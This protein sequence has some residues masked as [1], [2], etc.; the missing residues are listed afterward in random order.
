VWVQDKLGHP[1]QKS[2]SYN[3][4]LERVR[5]GKVIGRDQG[6]LHADQQWRQ[7]DALLHSADTDASSYLKAKELLREDGAYR[8]R[9]EMN[10]K[11]YGNYAFTVSGGK[12]QLQG[13]QLDSSES[14]TR[15]AV[16]SRRE[17]SELR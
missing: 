4:Q 9:F 13:R 15:I 12:I 8:I 6:E 7:L 5:D 16:E 1:Q 2:V 3:V 14:M 17:D 10:G 11:V